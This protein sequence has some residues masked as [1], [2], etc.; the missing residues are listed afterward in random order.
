MQKISVVTAFSNHLIEFFEDIERI[1]PDDDDIGAAKNYLL[2]IKKNNPKLLLTTWR[3]DIVKPYGEEITKGNIDFLINKNYD[4]DL[5]NFDDTG[6]IRQKLELLREPVKNLNKKDKQK[7]I[8]YFQNLT[9]I[10]S[11]DN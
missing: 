5:E 11:L 3:E 10:A 9:K 4:Y 1:F 2:F 8:K 7:V 6:E